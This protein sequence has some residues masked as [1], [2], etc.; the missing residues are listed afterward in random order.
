MIFSA[1]QGKHLE[2]I[3][4]IRNALFSNQATFTEKYLGCFSRDEKKTRDNIMNL[5]N[6]MEKFYD[7]KFN[8]NEKF[9]SYPKFK[10]S[11]KYS[12]LTFEKDN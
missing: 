8:F 5:K 11:G 1:Y 2:K 3:K 4:K 9:L 7:V 12:D 6:E 10:A